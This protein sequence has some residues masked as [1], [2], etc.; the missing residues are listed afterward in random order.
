MAHETASVS[1]G[2]FM[3]L[4]NQFST[5]FTTNSPIWVVVWVY[6]MSAVLALVIPFSFPYREA[7]WIFLGLVLG[8]IGTIA[9]FAWFGF[10][11]LTGLGH[12]VFWTPTLIYMVTVRGRGDYEKTL[13]SKWLLLGAFIIGASLLLD[14]IDALRWLLGERGP[15]KV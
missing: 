15:I 14:V 8:M 5:E 9:A 1:V 7:R 4:L 6:F 13:F 12:I 11:R 10:T 2:I 3:D